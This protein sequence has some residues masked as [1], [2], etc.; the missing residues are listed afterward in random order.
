MPSLSGKSSN[1][2]TR[3]TNTKVSYLK[4]FRRSLHLHCQLTYQF[5]ERLPETSAW[6]EILVGSKLNWPRALLTWK[7]IV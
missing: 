4:L 6:L 5:E 1:V 2:T 3:V 7:N